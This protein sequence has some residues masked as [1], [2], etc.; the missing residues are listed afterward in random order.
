MTSYSAGRADWRCK[1]LPM[2]RKLNTGRKKQGS[3]PPPPKVSGWKK[4][5]KVP[6]LRREV[7]WSWGVCLCVCVKIFI[8]KSS[9]L[10][11]FSCLPKSLLKTCNLMSQRATNRFYYTLMLL[12]TAC[13]MTSM[14]ITTFLLQKSASRWF[15]WLAVNSGQS[16]IC[17]LFSE[18]SD[19]L[20][21]KNNTVETEK[22]TKLGRG[23]G[24]ERGGLGRRIGKLENNAPRK[25]VR[26][27][28]LKS[29]FRALASALHAG[30]WSK[31]KKVF[32]HVLV[33]IICLEENTQC[34]CRVCSPV[35][36]DIPVCL[37]REAAVPQWQ[38]GVGLESSYSGSSSKRTIRL[39]RFKHCVNKQQSKSVL[40]CLITGS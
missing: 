14:Q 31:K 35:T 25:E 34:P 33:N 38:R 39:P 23:P 12:V 13:V 29:S 10:T 1:N 37:C 27:A 11:S 18:N 17:A 21:K 36:T 19:T 2:D 3:H 16:A 8:L 40:K 26:N 32:H 6:N 5:L 7:L 24:R 20:D 30:R 4:A 28:Q 22:W 15:Q 9:S